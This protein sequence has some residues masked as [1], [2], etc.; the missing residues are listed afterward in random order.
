MERTNQ[1]T[2]GKK[3]ERKKEKGQQRTRKVSQLLSIPRVH[4][5]LVLV[6]TPFTGCCFTALHTLFAV[7]QATAI[8]T[9]DASMYRSIASQKKTDRV[10]SATAYMC[11][12]RRRNASSKMSLK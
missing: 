12:A 4:S 1:R 5:P 2:N 9:D 11:G 8:A 6:R 10:R 3:K 7:Q